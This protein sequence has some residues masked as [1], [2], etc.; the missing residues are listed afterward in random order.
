MRSECT[1]SYLL[2]IAIFSNSWL[3]TMAMPCNDRCS[4]TGGPDYH[5]DCYDLGLTDIPLGCED[6]LTL[7]ASRNDIREIRTSTFRGYDRLE[8]LYINNNKI[9]SIA[10]GAFQPFATTLQSLDLGRNSLSRL[11]R[12]TFEN[13]VNLNQLD[14]RW[15]Q[16]VTIQSQAFNDMQNLTILLLSNNAINSLAL[17]VFDG[18]VSLRSLHLD[19]NRLVQ[20][21]SRLFANLRSLLHLRL[22]NNSI[23]SLDGEPLS[24]LL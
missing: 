6:A 4:Y 7:E 1:Q 18:L 13:M 2:V 11:D 23:T 8:Y 10:A 5:A 9:T 3:V 12:S 20:V 24:F 22:S 14:L 17:D 16:I 21:N 19:S 15:N